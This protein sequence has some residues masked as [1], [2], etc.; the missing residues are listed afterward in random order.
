MQAQHEH[1]D[2]NGFRL[3]GI[4]SSRLDSFS[5]VVFG[6][7]LT[8]IVVSQA[9]PRT[10]DQLQAILLG[11][12]PFATCF[13]I[14]V[15]LWLAHYRFFRRYGLHD[16]P[17]IAINLFLLFTVLFYVYPLKFLFTFATGHNTAGVFSNPYQLRKLMIVYGAGFT[18][19]H[20]CF[21]ALYGNAWRQRLQL[22]LN[23]LE[24]TLTLTA[25]WNYLG[26]VFVGLICCF[27]AW[28]LPANLS[29]R[30]GF[31][32]LLLLVWGRSHA[33]VTRRHIRMARSR[34]TPEDQLPL[35]RQI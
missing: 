21:A 23:P 32:F 24:T 25:F 16:T 13:L 5:D 19:I 35:S 26:N 27:L 1:I 12:I 3:R 20:L 7:A 9:V 22:R 29:G 15:S 30:A 33:I 11:F 18:A 6:F 17:T 8:L 10:Y 34:L 4:S 31:G 14:F 2:K 28:F